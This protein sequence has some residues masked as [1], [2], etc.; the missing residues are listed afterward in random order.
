[1]T[2]DPIFIR[3][4]ILSEQEQLAGKLLSPETSALLSTEY[5]SLGEQICAV[6]F[7][8]S[9]SEIAELLRHVA[10]LQGQ[11]ELIFALLAKSADSY[12]HLESLGNK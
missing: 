2:P 7:N 10:Y 4:M 5:H 11:R 1:M 9:D 3:P 12:A 8:G 6:K